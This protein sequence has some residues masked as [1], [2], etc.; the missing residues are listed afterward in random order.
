MRLVL[1]GDKIYNFMHAT[2]EVWEKSVAR[3]RG[4]SRFKKKSKKTEK[5]KNV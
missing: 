5:M 3:E 1:N 4:G 2:R